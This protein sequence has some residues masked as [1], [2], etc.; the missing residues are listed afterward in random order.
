MASPALSSQSSSL[1]QQLHEKQLLFTNWGLNDDSQTLPSQD[2]S[3]SSPAAPHATDLAPAEKEHRRRSRAFAEAARAAADKKLAKE[4]KAEKRAREAEKQDEGQEDIEDS[5][6]DVVEV[7]DLTQAHI[8]R[9]RTQTRPLPPPHPPRRTVS[10]ILEPAKAS[11]P[12]RRTNSTPLPEINARGRKR[13]TDA[14]DEQAKK[15]RTKVTAR[16]TK[17]NK[18]R[19]VTPP[20]VPEG[21][22]IFAGLSFYYLP[23]AALGARRLRI[24]KARQH[25]AQWVRSLREATHVVVDKQL[26]WSEV[27]AVV[28]DEGG[29]ETRPIVV[30]EEYPLDCIGFRCL[31]NPAQHRYRVRG[32][33]EGDVAGTSTKSKEKGKEKETD[34]ES[35]RRYVIKPDRR[36][37]AR[38]GSDASAVEHMVRSRR[39]GA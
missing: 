32:W 28:R 10:T 36:Q 33:T 6:D 21:Q 1:S 8:P 30:N 20:L 4:K 14:V 18:K 22:R 25:G 37:Q 34:R 15:A 17:A 3:S 16:S 35:P 13:K 2:I 31:L 23:D 26:A 9:S 38:L 11:A 24:A 12:L 19:D 27:A 39:G 7:I 5:D 29:D